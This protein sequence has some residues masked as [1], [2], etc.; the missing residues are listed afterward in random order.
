[1]KKNISFEEIKNSI[2]KPAT[3]PIQLQESVF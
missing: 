1:M 2:A 3:I